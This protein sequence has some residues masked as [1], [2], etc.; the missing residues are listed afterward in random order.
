[1][2]GLLDIAELSEEVEIKGKKLEVRGISA[3]GIANLMSKFPD[4]RKLVSGKGDEVTPEQLMDLAPGAIAIA[5]AAACGSPGDPAAEKI[6]G[7]LGVA[8][9]VKLLNVVLKLTF[10]GG[11]GPFVAD[12]THLVDSVRQVE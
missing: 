1:M 6:A 4:L 8:D 3:Q 5:I 10:P 9:Q 11:F 12:L 7:Q 2:V